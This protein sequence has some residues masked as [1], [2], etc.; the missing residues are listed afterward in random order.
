MVKVKMGVIA[1]ALALAAGTF[2]VSQASA[3]GCPS[4]SAC[5]WDDVG[6]VTQGS[7]YNYLG[8]ASQIRQYSAF[9]YNNTSEQVHD[10]SSSLRNNGNFS[11]CTFWVD[12]FFGGA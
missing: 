1:V 3:T 11:A 4:G 12:S 6:Y 5:V 10:N 7:T 8:S 9:N 2:S